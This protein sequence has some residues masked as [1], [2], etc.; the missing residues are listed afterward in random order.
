M[1]PVACPSCG[2]TTTGPFCSHCGTPVH[3]RE[4]GHAL[5]EGARFCNECGTPVPSS[6]AA[7]PLGAAEPVEPPHKRSAL[8]WVI[9]GV[10]VLALA[11]ALALILPRLNDEPEP[12][13][14][15][16]LSAPPVAVAPG[17]A[18][19]GDARSVDIASMTPRERADRLFDRVM[20]TLAQGDSVGARQFIPMALG[21]YELA[22]EPD[23]DA[24]YHIAALH[25]V[26]GD[27][28]AARAQ[29]DTILADSPQHLFGLFTA[30]E[31]EQE[32]GNTAEA[33]DLYR[34]F[35]AAYDA[36]F[37]RNLPEYQAHQLAL[38]GMRAE[39]ARVAGP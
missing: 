22:G 26:N 19:P 38:P 1:D 18:L 5:P 4:C 31:A 33:R 29:A 21:A 2:Q 39:A 35:L 32:R 37:A 28:T 30:A 20:R 7:T 23:T 13:L 34:R 9:A 6:A 3:C 11:G 8:P 12:A 14:T 16:R 25:L 27:A 24:R 10:A 15:G 36:E 17:A